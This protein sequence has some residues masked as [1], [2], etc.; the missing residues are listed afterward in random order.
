VPI[1]GARAELTSIFAKAF[2][3][4]PERRYFSAKEFADDLQRYLGRLPVSAVEGGFAYR[5]QCF[6]IRQKTMVVVAF[7]LLLAASGALLMVLRNR[8]LD[9]SQEQTIFFIR[10]TASAILDQ[11]KAQ[12]CSG[13]PRQ[14][15]RFGSEYRQR[16]SA[17]IQARP[18]LTRDRQE[19]IRFMRAQWSESERLCQ[20]NPAALLALAN[21]HFEMGL[22]RGYPNEINLGDRQGALESFDDALRLASRANAA[23][24][25][26]AADLI[27][28]IHHRQAIVAA[29]ERK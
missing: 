15:E 13:Q 3:P 14:I 11:V 29:E 20:S 26:R 10:Q 25:D 8:E 6:V 1:P 23:N 18:G 27:E 28:R 12:N 9:A 24:A 17:L 22:L 19:L 16:F 4:I 5:A 7:L 21:M 2:Q